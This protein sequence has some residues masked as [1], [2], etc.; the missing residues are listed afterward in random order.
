MLV[1]ALEMEVGD[2]EADIVSLKADDV[3]FFIIIIINFI[4]LFRLRFF[5]FV[6]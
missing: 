5:F 2:E 3:N 6:M 4:Y 1:H